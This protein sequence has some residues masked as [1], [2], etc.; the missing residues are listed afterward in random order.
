MKLGIRRTGRFT[1]ATA[2]A[3]AL[4]ATTTAAAGA[5]EATTGAASL[6]D[7]LFPQLG[8]GG[9]D[10]R[11]YDVGFDYRPGSM[12]MASTV[13]M[14]AVATQNLSGFSLDSAGQRLRTVRVNG[15]PARFR[16]TGEKLRI[17]PERP[18]RRGLPFSVKVDY[19]ADRGANPPSPAYD[20]P[21]GLE[22]PLKPWVNAPDGFALMGQPDRAHVFFPS[23]D[24]PS[25]KALFTFRVSTPKD[26]TAVANGALAAKTTA[27]GRTTFVYRTDHPIPTDVVQVAVGHFTQVDQI[28]PAGL[29]LR[30]YAAAGRAGE[31]T[32]AIRRTPAQVAWAERTLGLGFP[33]S[34][35]GQLA[36]DS[37]Y[38]GVALETATLSTFSAAG[39][40]LPDERE[41]PVQVHELIHQWFGDAVSPRTWDDMWLNE[42]HATYYQLRYAADRGLQTMD[43]AMKGIYQAAAQT[44]SAGPP[45]RL[46]NA[47]GVLFDTDAGGAIT[48]YA[49]RQQVG[50]RT[51]Q[52]IERTFLTTYRD[53][54]ASTRDYIAVANRVSGRD[55]TG[56]FNAWLYDPEMPSMPGHPDWTAPPPADRTTA[57]ATT[58]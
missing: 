32:P 58:H 37:G 51:F 41:S 4:V 25:D 2:V 6:G 34:S 30:G 35:Y 13:T 31:V 57:P 11:A 24:H 55:L 15:R 38:D 8:N 7:R 28:G 26:L 17:T 16:L 42:G 12:T 27:N 48:L 29:P 20:L 19:V 33:Y 1:A 39:L 14:T 44:R 22:W 18:L 54:S 49:L 36:V 47:V 45:A 21:E 46:G 9:Y 43:Q 10:A 5:D 56:L 50:D 3:A 52:Q 40:A 53:R 23:N